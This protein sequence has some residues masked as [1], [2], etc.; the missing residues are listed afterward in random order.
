MTSNS[1][2][3]EPCVFKK[4][5]SVAHKESTIKHHLPPLVLP[6]SAVLSV[7]GKPSG[8]TA[9][10]DMLGYSQN[11]VNAKT[12]LLLMSRWCFISECISSSLLSNNNNNYYYYQLVKELIIQNIQLV[13]IKK[14]ESGCSYFM[15]IG[16]K[17]TYKK[18]IH[19]CSP[20]PHNSREW[21]GNLKSG[22]EVLDLLFDA[23]MWCCRCKASHRLKHWL[24]YTS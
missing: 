14:Y 18:N 20:V 16:N 1:S 13:E 23:H 6:E 24:N 2:S 22:I 10:S 4:R 17:L 8:M 21:A 3:G 12:Q 7:D 5:T 9:Q 11:S 15:P 19:F